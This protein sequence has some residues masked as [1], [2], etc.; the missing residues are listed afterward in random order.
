MAGR[1]QEIEQF[2]S[3]LQDYEIIANGKYMMVSSR[4]TS[5]VFPKGT[6]V[7]DLQTNTTFTGDG[8]T[9]GGFLESGAAVEYADKAGELIGTSENV[10]VVITD[11]GDDRGVHVVGGELEVGTAGDPRESVF[12]GG[13]SYPVPVAFHCDTGSTSGLTITGATNVTAALQS[14][15]GSSTGLL[16]GT[17]AGKYLLVGSDYQF[18]GVKVKAVNS[19]DIE[20]DNLR[21]ESWI[22]DGVYNPVKLMASNANYPH[23]Q[24]A[25]DIGT[26]LNEQ[27]RFGFDPTSP[28]NWVPVT[29]NIN[30][31]N[32]TKYWGRYVIE[33]SIA[34]D[35]TV[36]QLKCHTSRTE[37]NA[38]G[39]LE[40]FGLARYP[41]TLQA[42]LQV[43]TPNK[44]IDPADEDVAYGDGTTAKY[45]DNEFEANKDDGFLV[46]QGIENGLDT[47]IPLQLNLSYYVKGSETGNIV[48][49]FDVYQV[50]D[51][52]V[53]DGTA[54]PDQYSV[55][56]T[57]S[58]DSNLVR[59]SASVQ[60]NAEHVKPGEA[61]TISVKRKGAT[62]PLDTVDDNIVITYVSLT[63][64]FWR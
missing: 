8:S 19:G 58:S 50:G 14:D 55:T 62:N 12:G 7:F 37:L 15:S 54:I 63:G 59:R 4:R 45:K 27:W 3:Q 9:K 26:N 52:F 24:Y 48:F 22:G 35:M 44:L 51:G 39:T 56:D 60:I 18:Q 23:N 32:I 28:S 21:L 64:H 25:H 10:S 31:S 33:S 46:I 47:S 6:A 36:E 41:K 53:Y 29:L 20:V 38:T 49:D 13:D 40:F 17:T 34:T 42:G 2:E 61:L 30:G 5:F 11:S 16:G 1:I 57:V 43:A